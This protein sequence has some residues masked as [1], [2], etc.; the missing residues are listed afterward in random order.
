M[1]LLSRLSWH[2]NKLAA[3]RMQSDEETSEGPTFRLA[4]IFGL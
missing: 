3:Y 4:E 1:P 2:F